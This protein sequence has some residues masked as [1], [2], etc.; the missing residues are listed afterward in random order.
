MLCY[1]AEDKTEELNLE[2][3]RDREDLLL[4]YRFTVEWSV[5]SQRMLAGF[6]DSDK[7]V[8]WGKEVGREGL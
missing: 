2:E 1:R 3:K 6:R 5:G 7:A 8:N 4:A